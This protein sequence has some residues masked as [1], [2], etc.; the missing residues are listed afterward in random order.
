MRIA[1]HTRIQAARGTRARSC[2]E[3]L[4]HTAVVVAGVV[5]SSFTFTVTSARARA[6]THTHTH[7][8][9]HAYTPPPHPH[10]RGTY[11]K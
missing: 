10:T 6:G 2:C 11:M 8:V 1:P 9:A 7:T 3:K 4:H 5:H